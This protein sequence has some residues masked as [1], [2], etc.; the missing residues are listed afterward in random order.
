MHRP[1]N[2]MTVIVTAIA[3]VANC[4]GGN[5]PELGS[6]APLQDGGER[7]VVCPENYARVGA[8]WA[9]VSF[10]CGCDP[11][12]KPDKLDRPGLLQRK[13]ISFADATLLLLKLSAVLH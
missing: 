7:G 1:T 13:R 10:A 3:R 8:R 2:P 11:I 12:P 6:Q 9:V 4:C 5:L